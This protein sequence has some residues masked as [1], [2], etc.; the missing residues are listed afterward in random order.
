M[1]Y[2]GRYTLNIFY[3]FFYSILK[4]SRVLKVCN[5]VNL[6]APPNCLP[7]SLNCFGIFLNSFGAVRSR[8]QWSTVN[9]VFHF[10]YL[11]IV[12]KYAK[13]IIILNN[14][15]I[16]Q[17]YIKTNSIVKK[18][19]KTKGILS[20]LENFAK[21]ANLIFPGW[22][23]IVNL[24]AA[25]VRGG[26]LSDGQGVY[27]GGRGYSPL[28]VEAKLHSGQIRHCCRQQSWPRQSQSRANDR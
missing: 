23:L 18:K 11:L 15:L 26:L 21:N 22:K 19:K 14:I 1:I 20:C 17:K 25:R 6:S 7:D 27:Q 24:R 16:G 3:D 28:S 12:W 8:S 2:V 4:H 5:V 9:Y 10:F 13:L